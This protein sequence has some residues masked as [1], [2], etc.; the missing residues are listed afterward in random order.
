MTMSANGRFLEKCTA[1]GCVI[2]A[3]ALAFTSLLISDDHEIASSV[4]MVIAQ[5]LLFAASVFGIDY[6]FNQITTPK[7]TQQ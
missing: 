2:T 6:K 7:K 1:V 3:T 5:F 4:I